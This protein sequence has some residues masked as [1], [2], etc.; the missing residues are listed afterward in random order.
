MA[1]IPK[2]LGNNFLC[3]WGFVLDFR[4]FAWITTQIAVKYRSH[5]GISPEN[6]TVLHGNHVHNACGSGV[7]PLTRH[8]HTTSSH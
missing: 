1:Y 5:K 8:T 6:Q 3:F 4:S 2:K 7:P